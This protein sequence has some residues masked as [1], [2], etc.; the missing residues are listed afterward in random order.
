MLI[1]SASLACPG[2]SI[3]DNSVQPA[4]VR[5]RGL[6]SGFSPTLCEDPVEWLSRTSPWPRVTSSESFFFASA[7]GW[8]VLNRPLNNIA[9]PAAWLEIAPGQELHL[10]QIP[11]FAPSPFEAGE[12]GRHIAI[13]LT[14]SAFR[15]T[16]GSSAAARRSAGRPVAGNAVRALLLR[17]SGRATSSRWSRSSVRL[18]QRTPLF[19]L[20]GL[21]ETRMRTFRSPSP[22][23]PL[24]AA[25]GRGK[26]DGGVQ[27]RQDPST[28]VRPE[29]DWRN[30]TAGT[31]QCP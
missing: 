11:D 29:K 4:V 23:A 31:T 5:S 9:V 19:P 25:P 13:R 28:S 15:R 1:G 20:R 17:R 18:V 7:L 22:P 24:P 26:T 16:Q 12:Y 14:P 21:G 8:Q 3:A 27:A 30:Y 10:V 6:A 2:A